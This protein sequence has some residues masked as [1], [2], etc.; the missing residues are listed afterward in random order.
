[1]KKN[2]KKNLNVGPLGAHA[3]HLFSIDLLQK[4]CVG[5][6]P[7]GCRFSEKI[8]WRERVVFREKTSESPLENFS[9]NIENQEIMLELLPAELAVPQV[10][11]SLGD[12][13]AWLEFFTQG[14]R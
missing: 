9:E 14:E 11:T 12:A 10:G 3:G 13:P 6:I 5:C 1:L 4:I 2:L 7:R 8:L